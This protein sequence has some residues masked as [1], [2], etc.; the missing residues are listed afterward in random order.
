MAMAVYGCTAD[1]V[2]LI[3]ETDN[4]V[5][6][7]LLRN[8]SGQPVHVISYLAVS[9]VLQQDLGRLVASFPGSKEQRGL[10]LRQTHRHT[11][12]NVFTVDHR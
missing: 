6:H 3:H 10:L 12:R 2:V 9:K 11:E 7:P 1:Q 4:V 5:V 8:V